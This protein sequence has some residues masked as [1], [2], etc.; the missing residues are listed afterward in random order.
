MAGHHCSK[1]LGSELKALEN[2][3]APK[4]PTLGTTGIQKGNVQVE[5]V[6]LTIGLGPDPRFKRSEVLPV[7]PF[8]RQHATAVVDTDKA[9]YPHNTL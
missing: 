6:C 9:I 8:F 3:S 7:A 2:G 5:Q 1:V 4:S